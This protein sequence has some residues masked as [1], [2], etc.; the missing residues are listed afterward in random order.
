[1]RQERIDEDND[2][3]PSHSCSLKQTNSSLLSTT[4]VINNILIFDYQVFTDDH[5]DLCLPEQVTQHNDECL[6]LRNDWVTL[7]LTSDNWASWSSLIRGTGFRLEACHLNNEEK[8]VRLQH[9]TLSTL[10]IMFTYVITVTVVYSS[11]YLCEVHFLFSRRWQRI[12]RC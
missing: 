11:F 6:L 10:F 2:I 3:Q 4:T 5:C 8:Y 9:K 1:M 7:C 12:I